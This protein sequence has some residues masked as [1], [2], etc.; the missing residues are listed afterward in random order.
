MRNG[1]VRRE[2]KKE[3]VKRREKFN[4]EVKV[5]NGD[6]KNFVLEVHDSIFKTKGDIKNG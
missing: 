5:G 2:R 4:N 3:R 6:K 1:R